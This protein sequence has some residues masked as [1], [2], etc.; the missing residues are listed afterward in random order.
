MPVYSIS[1]MLDNNHSRMNPNT[2]HMKLKFWPKLSLVGKGKSQKLAPVWLL[3]HSK[4][5]FSEEWVKRLSSGK[6]KIM[7]HA[8]TP[9][10]LRARKLR[11]KNGALEE[12]LEM[13]KLWHR[14]F[15]DPSHT[16]HPVLWAAPRS[17]VPP[18]STYHLLFKGEN[19]S[20]PTPPSSPRSFISSR[21]LRW[22]L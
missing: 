21:V 20:N 19:P 9:Q 11:C 18:D 1:S 8:L 22:E 10:H 14:L 17:E 2:S 6:I 5:C 13:R 12:T 3:K 16:P 15:K 7:H 4:E